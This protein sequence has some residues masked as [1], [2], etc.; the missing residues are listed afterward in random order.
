MVT[1]K[2]QYSLKNARSYFKEHLAHGD[3]YSEKESVQG[4]WM[5]AG[6]AKLGLHGA[7]D[8]KAKDTTVV[9]T[10]EVQRP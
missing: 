5:G 7:V 9:V 6:A 10:R 2:T 1:P 8:Q 3:Y 4:E